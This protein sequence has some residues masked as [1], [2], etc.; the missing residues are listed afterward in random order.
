MAF[1]HYSLTAEAQSPCLELIV[2]GRFGAIPVFSE[3]FQSGT[4]VTSLSLAD[5]A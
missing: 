3:R 5:A 1:L 4:N 2:N